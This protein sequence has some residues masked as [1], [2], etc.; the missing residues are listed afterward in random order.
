MHE[1][2]FLLQ[3]DGNLFAEAERLA[4]KVGEKKAH[5]SRAPSVDRGERT[6][7]VEAIK[8]EMGIHLH[9]KRFELRFTSEDACLI[10]ALLGF[11]RCF[12]GEQDVVQ[13]DCEQIKKNAASEEQRI[14][15]VD[16][17]IESAEG[18]KGR[19]RYGETFCDQQPEEA[20]D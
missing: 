14:A 1:R 13:R 8:K 18:V 17:P 3:R 7:G 12:N 20:Q 4:Q 16:L 6:N 5:L 19:E 9:F 2:K 10:F 11:A 15:S